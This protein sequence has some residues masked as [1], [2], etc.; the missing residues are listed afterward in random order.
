MTRYAGPMFIVLL[1][2]PATAQ[3]GPECFSRY[4]RHN[5]SARG[6]QAR[7]GPM[8]PMKISANVTIVAVLKPSASALSMTVGS[9][10]GRAHYSAGSVRRAGP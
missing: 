4:I 2:Q 7:M 8:L 1:S 10:A 9:Q 3:N 6:L 5:E